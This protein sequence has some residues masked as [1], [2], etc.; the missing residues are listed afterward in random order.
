[1]ETHR[2]P[3]AADL[4]DTERDALINAVDHLLQ[5]APRLLPSID[6]VLERP[7]G[8]PGAAT[9]HGRTATD[10]DRSEFGHERMDEHLRRL[11]G[12]GWEQ[13]A[14]LSDE[15][16]LRGADGTVNRN[17]ATPGKLAT[18]PAAVVL[19]LP[20]QMRFPNGR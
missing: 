12:P 19:I 6:G 10:D 20:M 18:E 16:L 15:F 11:S 4:D 1:M 13:H 5:F 8:R 14:P 7:Q 17:A 2:D 9:G 3:F